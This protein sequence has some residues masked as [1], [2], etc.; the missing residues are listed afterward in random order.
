M[1]AAIYARF[2]TDLQSDRSV[3]DQVA[4][5]RSHAAKLG[6]AVA[7]VFADRAASGASIHGRPDYQRLIGLALAGQFDVI[8]TEDLDRLSRNLADIARLYETAQFAGVKLVTVADGEI[9]E[10]HIG[11]KGTMS[12]LF[13]KGLAQKVRRGLSGVVRDGRSAGGR[14]YGYKPVPGRPGELAIVAEEAAIVRRI[15]AEYLAGDSARIIAGRLNDEGVPPPRGRF[16]SAVTINGNR[17]RG[18]GLLLNP[19]YAGRLVWNRVRM[20]KDPATGRRISRVNASGEHQEKA[21][22]HLAIVDAATFEAVRIRREGRG[23]NGPRERARP[24][25]ILS[26]LLRCGG[27]GGGMSVKDRDHGRVRIRCT[28]ATE[29]GSCDNRRSYYLDRVEQAVVGGLRER[30]ADREAIALYVRSYNEERQRLAASTIANRAQI[31]KRLAAAE[32]EHERI[33]RAYVK[34]LIEED[35]LERELPPL[36]AERDRLRAELAAAE[37]PPRVVALH[38]ATVKRYLASIERLEATIAEGETHGGEAK[39]ALRDLIRTVTIHPAP[40]GQE[41]AIDVIGELTA[42]IGGAHF[43][44]T[45]SGGQMVAGGR[46]VRAPPIENRTGTAASV[47]VY[48][49]FAA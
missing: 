20:V 25:H 11:L 5:C 41:P 43:P 27:C 47:F 42:L 45:R 33:Y 40:A 2:S 19:I 6:L 9:S 32:R 8:L 12:A 35:A 34:G 29:S 38:P 23:L 1:R 30:M 4:L 31:E 17:T 49:R 44:T 7:D 22:P 15:F 37:E 26:G 21:V 3:E 39:E 14:A 46:S 10:M 48:G 18:H 16:W 28:T 13:L 24:R 36:K